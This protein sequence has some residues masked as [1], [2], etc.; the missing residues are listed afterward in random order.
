MIKW[1]VEKTANDV[2]N[3]AVRIFQEQINKKPDSIL[4]LA[5]GA[6]PELFYRKL[7]ALHALG[8]ISFQGCRTFNLDEYCGLPKDHYQSY[9][10]YMEK[11]LFGHVDINKKKTYLPNGLA[12]DPKAECQRYDILLSQYGPIDLQLLGI[13]RNGH[14][15]FNEPNSTLMAKTHIV[16]LDPKTIKDNARFFA[17]EEEVP[18]SAI[19]MGLKGIQEAKRIVLLATGIEKALILKALK[20]ESI[21]T[22]LPASFLHLHND[23]TI[24]CDEAAGLL[25]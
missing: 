14:I 13:G 24:I 9:N 5:T 8:K 3:R 15:G 23:V 1:Y 22:S 10:Y 19:T 20:S 17:S 16:D 18:K 6:T 25:I 11:N 7:V 2:A 4:G 21:S 12:E